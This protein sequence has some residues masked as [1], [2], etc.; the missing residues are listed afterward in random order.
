MG[1]GGASDA[2]SFLTRERLI[3]AKRATRRS[4]APDETILKRPLNFQNEVACQVKVR[5]KVKI[6]DFYV[7]GHRDLENGSFGPK[8]SPS[9]PKPQEQELIELMFDT[10]LGSRSSS[11]HKRSPYSYLISVWC[12]DRRWTRGRGGTIVRKRCARAHVQMHPTSDLCKPL[13]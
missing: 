8:L 10:E 2:P 6:G 12:L 3:A 1:I 5:S 9:T 13:I 11:G 4:K 7:T